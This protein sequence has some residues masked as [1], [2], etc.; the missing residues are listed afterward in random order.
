MIFS[1]F[2]KRWSK[3]QTQPIKYWL[4]PEV[5]IID[6]DASARIWTL[7]H[8]RCLTLRRR[9]ELRYERLKMKI[10]SLF[11]FRE[12]WWCN[13]RS[14]FSIE[15][16]LNIKRKKCIFCLLPS[17]PLSPPSSQTTYEIKIIMINVIKTEKKTA[18]KTFVVRRSSKVSIFDS[19]NSFAAL[20]SSSGYERMNVTKHENWER[21][22]RS[23][24]RDICLKDVIRAVT[25]QT[26]QFF[27]VQLQL[28]RT[29]TNATPNI[30]TKWNAWCWTNEK[31][32]RILRT[33]RH[34]ACQL[35]RHS[36]TQ[37]YL[38]PILRQTHK[39]Q[40]ITTVNSLFFYEF[41]W[42][43]FQHVLFITATS[44]QSIHL[45]LYQLK[46]HQIV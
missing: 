38:D 32:Y 13:D 34:R 18:N 16:T 15:Q 35:D 7:R 31:W 3:W 45:H 24:E 23:V 2:E 25:Q 44:D 12:C 22:S 28:R 20:S 43:A 14:T 39:Q 4:L 21:T 1:L 46:T 36:P 41:L 19:Q 33:F 6:I 10:R 42:R 26:I 29:T 5:L 17:S 8:K 37:L 30:K 9:I 27:V 40:Y 11:Y